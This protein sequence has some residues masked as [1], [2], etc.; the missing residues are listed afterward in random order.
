MKENILTF[1]LLSLYLISFIPKFKAEPF[2]DHKTK[3][4]LNTFIEKPTKIDNSLLLDD[5]IYII[6]NKDGNQNLDIED[7]LLFFVDYPKKE[8][9][10]YFRIFTIDK[11]G[12]NKIHTKISNNLYCIED[13]DNYKRIGVLNDEGDI[14]L[15]E[16]QEGDID[17]GYN[18][19]QIL[20]NI[21]PK[22]FEEKDNNI[23]YQRV[24]YYLKNVATG[25]FSSY[26]QKKDKGILICDKDNIDEFTEDNYFIFNK[27]YRESNSNESLDLIEKEPIDV[28]IK[29]ID[30]SDP[31]LKR[32][33][34]KQIK[35]DRDNQELKYSVRSILKY[36]PWIRKIFILM[37]NEKVRF[38]K[39]PEE[40]KDKIV[41]VQDKDLIGFDSASSP[42][43]QFNLW[44]MKKF[45]L[46]EN[47]IL[48]DDDYFIGKPLKKSNFFYEE[49]GQIYPALITNDYYELSKNKLKK[50]LEPFFA[51]ITNINPHNENG[52]SF[53]QENSLLF[54]YD[55][56][57]DDNIRHG[58][59]LIEPS[60]TH[61]AIPVKQSDIKEIYHYI[62]K[63]YP[64][65]DDTLRAKEREIFSLQPQTIFM[66]YAR[67]KY[68]RRVKVI[69]SYF[70]DLKQFK[71]IV[72]SDLFVIN[73]S[74][75]KYSNSYF[76]K[77]IEY[78]EKLY[79]EKTPYELGLRYYKKKNNNNN[80]NNN[81]ISN[82]NSNKDNESNI[83]NEV[84]NDKSNGITKIEKKKSNNN[85]NEDFSKKDI[86]KEKNSLYQSI[87][88]DLERSFLEKS[89]L[90][91][92]ISGI[93]NKLNELNSQYDQI[94]IQIEEL[95]KQFNETY[96]KKI[97]LSLK[98]NIQIQE[99]FR[100]K[101]F[102]APIIII[103]LI[104]FLYCLIK[105][106]Y[107]HKN[108][109]NN[110]NVINYID[111]NSLN[112]YRKENEMFLI[113]SKIDI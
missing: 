84:K 71:G 8:L 67:N 97:F 41:Y 100:T 68:D 78:L 95:S 87:I 54:L 14:G 96:S 102:F 25:K 103:I 93:K 29:Y 45:G 31:N 55:I 5:A 86:N 77:E 91:N 70:F 48:M 34:I 4:K 32:E 109:F 52:F 17:N 59:P 50:D 62:E 35:K 9:K 51:N 57:G 85:V 72:N 82:K 92:D 26:K 44:Q 73:V 13:K 63:L 27:I 104:I 24:Y 12:K 66:G 106:V 111:I 49:K 28:L 83:S 43:F 88:T 76:T 21:I 74:N 11:R 65:K 69:S 38:F 36:I 42:V 22:L 80:N 89:T 81:N 6:R 108:S 33:G 107:F 94:S 105:R 20:W 23:T 37:P 39:P 40:I 19:D 1:L 2:L 110:D 18:N 64:H 75:K 61:N 112:G 46:S 3:L 56:L 15:F 16:K 7:N 10:R 113:N 60:F 53:M 30:L 90:N 98:Q 79:P 101:L 58:Q 99:S 47:F